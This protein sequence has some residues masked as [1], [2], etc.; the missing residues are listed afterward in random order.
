VLVAFDVAPVREQPT[1]VGIFAA[2][3]GAALAKELGP[4]RL[5]LIGRRDHVDGLPANVP[6]TRLARGGYIQWLQTQASRDARR[7][8]ADLAHYS[9]GMTPLFGRRQTVLSVHD[10]SVV[11][12]W[13]THPARRLLR[14]PLALMGP[15]LA[16]LV[17]VPSRATADEVMALSRIS[18]RKIELMP[19][20]P[21]RRLEP[22]TD[23]AIH[24]TL[25]TYGLERDGYILALGTIE[26][27][28]NLVR[29]IDAFE[30]LV[31]A[32]AIDSDLQLVVAGDARWGS[33]TVLDR[34]RESPAAQRIKRLG[35]VPAEDVGPLLSA[36]AVVAYLSL[37]EGFGL[38]VVE[39]MAC[40]AAT[41]TSNLS[42]MPEVAGDAAFLVDPR[43]TEDIAR[44][45]Q[46]ALHAAGTDRARVAARAIAQANTFSWERAAKTAAELYA[47]QLGT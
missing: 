34:I 38:P 11:R 36:A 31:S 28:K 35:Y 14:I 46:G 47:K 33:G 7:V 40:G 39:A 27:R 42:S 1:G 25:A 5:A 19:Y 17:V 26:P 44:G 9:D 43:A 24:S 2:S 45:L 30:R 21:Q 18:A 15:R 37:Y 12:M 16:D 23:E 10:M 41:V 3:M 8:R 32:D 13:R 6:S 4:G 22:A 29:L 20:A